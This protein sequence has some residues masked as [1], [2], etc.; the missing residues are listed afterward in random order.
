MEIFHTRGLSEARAASGERYHEFL[1]KPTLSVGLYR[2][3]AGSDDPQTPHASDEV[4]IVVS[5]R[6]TIRVGDEHEVVEPGSVVFVERG[7][8]HEF[9]SIEEELEVLVFFAPAEPRNDDPSA[10]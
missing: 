3:G 1:R 7:V 5:G 4:Y 6:A 8:D 9:H 2:L 10:A